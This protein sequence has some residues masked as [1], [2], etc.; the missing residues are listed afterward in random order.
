MNTLLTGFSGALAAVIFSSV[1]GVLETTVLVGAAVAALGVIHVKVLRPMVQFM[2][3][4]DEVLDYVRSV[5]LLSERMGAVEAKVDEIIEGQMHYE[6][7]LAGIENSLGSLAATER[8]TIKQVL[9]A[10]IRPTP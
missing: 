1:D 9:E 5:P 3:R 6:G 8:R 4:V 7:R 10:D 2:G